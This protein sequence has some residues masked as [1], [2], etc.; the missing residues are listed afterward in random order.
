MSKAQTTEERVWASIE[1]VNK[2]IE[3]TRQDT[4]RFRQNVEKYCQ[5]G[6]KIRQE[7]RESRQESEKSRQNLEKS[8][9]ELKKSQNILHSQWARLVESLVGGRLLDLLNSRGIDVHYIAERAKRFYREEGNNRFHQTEFDIIAV[10]GCEIVAIEVK[11]TLHPE[12]VK[13]FLEQLKKFKNYF[14]EYQSHKIYGAVAYLNCDSK[15]ATFAEKQGL[16]V[17]KAVGDSARLI[18]DKNFK[19]KTFC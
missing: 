17:I 11:T 14:K 15:A 19:P 6:E 8:M 2:D 1:R 7:M 12:D 5:D 16:F 13:E 9:R 4:E 18:N 10:N 3:R